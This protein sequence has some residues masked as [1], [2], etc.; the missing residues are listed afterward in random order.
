MDKIIWWMFGKQMAAFLV[1]FS[2]FL[3]EQLN[4]NIPES[5][6]NI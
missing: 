2:A 5:S 3:A 1:P 6:I 4:S